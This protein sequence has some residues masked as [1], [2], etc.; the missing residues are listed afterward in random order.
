MSILDAIDVPG[1]WKRYP[2]GRVAPRVQES[3]QPNLEP[4]SVFLD[5]GVVP[6]A[7]RS[8]NHNQLGE[9]LE[10][11][12]V[13]RPGDIVFNKL[14]TWQGGLGVSRH[15]GIVSPAYFV[16]RPS[17]QFD[18]RYLHY[19]LRSV[20]YLQELT[21]IS[22]W[23]PPSQFDVG[24]EEL[25]GLPLVA[26]DRAVQEEIADFLD[27]EIGRID[28][29]NE[30]R[31]RMVV[32]LEERWSSVVRSVISQLTPVMPL[33]R[34]WR[35]TDCKHRTP[36]YIPD[37]YPV[38]SP[39]DTTAGRLDL[40]RCH[41]F[42]SEDDLVDLTE[43]RQPRRGDII[44]SRNA[45]AGIASYVDTDEPF[46]MG[47]D[48]CLVTSAEQNQ[49]YLMYAL[50]SLGADQLQPLKI[51]STITRI[52]VDQIGELL[53][54][55]PAPDVQARIARQLDSER[56]RVDDILSRLLSQLGCIQERRQALITAAV[57]GQLDL[58]KAAA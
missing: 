55:A 26:P 2:L 11:Y 12:L 34:R 58:T 54:P 52:N 19:Q 13:V 1:N 9:N 8:D 21:R 23:M 38:V 37:G 17:A 18:S 46:C 31:R 4:L 28:A 49:L 25:R 32:L 57:T 3:G 45:S 22:K 48:V 39:G 14:R 40:R 30:K 42:V 50:N 27:A 53:L 5:V 20:P 29:L 44:Y 7:T 16:C 56:R 24:W 43:G 10:K 47:Q 6:R 36:T 41:R 33:K 15:E 51:G 35:I